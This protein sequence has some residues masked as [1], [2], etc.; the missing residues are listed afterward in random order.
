MTWRATTSSPPS[1][2]YILSIQVTGGRERERE[3]EG[4]REG[5]GERGELEKRREGDEKYNLSY[6]IAWRSLKHTELITD[7]WR[8]VE[9]K[10]PSHNSHMVDKQ[11]PALHLRRKIVTSDWP[12]IIYNFKR[13]TEGRGRV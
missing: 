8:A 3:R 12:S 5:E 9:K 11:Q 10:Y 2:K 7:S 6:D 13:E 1:L 4:G